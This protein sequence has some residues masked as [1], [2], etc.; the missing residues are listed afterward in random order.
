MDDSGDSL[1]LPVEVVKE[2]SVEDDCCEPDE[3]VATP[4][5][6]AAAFPTKLAF[7]T[8]NLST[9]RQYIAPPEPSMAL[10]YKN[11]TPP[12]IEASISVK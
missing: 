12:A 1:E 5:P 8:Y 9:P 11:W 6:Q 4:P 2:G 10:L 7:L 3:N